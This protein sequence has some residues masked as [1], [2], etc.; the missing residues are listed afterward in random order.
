MRIR[1]ASY[2][3]RDK[4]GMNLQFVY[5]GYLV[6]MSVFMIFVCRI[7]DRDSD[8]RL[9]SILQRVLVTGV[10]ASLLYAGA[11]IVSSE[12]HARLLY[13]LYF[14]VTDFLIV[15]TYFYV[16]E[17]SDV[18]CRPLRAKIILYTICAADT[19]S[20]ILNT[21]SENV[22]RCVP[23]AEESQY[24]LYRIWNVSLLFILHRVFIVVMLAVMLSLLLYKFLTSSMSY[25]RKYLVLFLMLMTVVILDILSVL[26]RVP[27]DLADGAFGILGFS[28]YYYSFRFIPYDLVE[29]LLSA[30]IKNMNDGVMCFDSE[31]KCI[32][33][34]E[35]VENFSG[36]KNVPARIEDLMKY[37]KDINLDGVESMDWLHSQDDRYYHVSYKVI[38]DRLGGMSGCFFVFH[39]ETEEMEKHRTESYRLLH[40]K[41]TDLYNRE[42]FYR[43]VRSLLDSMEDTEFIMLCSDIKDFKLVNDVFGMD[44]GDEL[45]CRIAD[46]LRILDK[47]N[48]KAIYGRMSGDRF[49]VCMP[50]KFFDEQKWNDSIRRLGDFSENKAYHVYIHL[51]VYEIRDRSI[52]ISVMCDRAFMAINNIK[53]SYNDTV[54]HYDE[55]IREA[56]IYEKKITGEF[57]EAIRN[58]QFRMFLQPQINAA[59]EMTGAEALVRWFHPEQGVIPPLDFIGVFERSG[60]IGT[61]DHHIWECACER[62]KKWK[63]EGRGQYHISVNISPKDFYFMDIYEIFTGLV[64]KYDIEPAMLKLEITETAIITDV[65]N[66][67]ALVDRLRE[68]GFQVEID[69]FGSGYSSLS[70]LKEINADVVKVDMGFLEKVNTENLAKSRA[71]LS[72]IV[73][74]SKS[75]GMEVVTEGV[76]TKDQVD[77]LIREG[78]DVFQGYYFDRPMSTEDFEK[79]YF[80]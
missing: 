50:K 34:N 13:G 25:K 40:D 73:R 66:H 24:R 64:K 32:Y 47:Y 80:S 53:D 11:L 33:V 75:L 71:I 58:G 44:K 21:V 79:K 27:V 69:D 35:V 18:S 6:V 55:K 31:G 61:L 36:K 68:Y 15:M 16:R 4:G 67:L 56:R 45:L 52:E 26:L 78:C 23:V 72:A 5:A 1:V 7:A 62:L 59:G 39:D 8:S 49:A 65:K 74:L 37:H 43:R 3:S 10:A 77:F 76:E 20:M 63:D 29:Q 54:A 48:G 46:A 42:Y 51:G 30:A 17:F 41:L 12:I 70:M 14:S 38:S 19:V 57:N 9:A 28:I 2:V 22:F 60:L